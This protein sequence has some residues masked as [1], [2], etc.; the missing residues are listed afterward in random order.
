MA[1]HVPSI[2][3]WYHDIADS[4]LFKIIAIDDYTL[5]I[6][7]RYED[8][9]YSDIDLNSWSQMAV[10]Q[11][12]PPQDW[13]GSIKTIDSEGLFTDSLYSSAADSDPFA[14]IEPDTRFGWDE[15]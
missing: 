7:I 6:D 4:R 3:K 11:T 13:H 5:N 15:Y 1:T 14:G 12:S 8:G 10:V 2:G 9:E